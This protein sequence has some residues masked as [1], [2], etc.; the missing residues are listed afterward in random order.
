M[1]RC[2]YCRACVSVDV[3]HIKVLFRLRYYGRPFNTHNVS[4]HTQTPNTRTRIAQATTQ[5]TSYHGHRPEA[6]AKRSAEG[7]AR[8]SA[9]ARRDANTSV[10]LAHHA[11]ALQA[12]RTMRLSRPS[13]SYVRP[14]AAHPIASGFPLALMS[15]GRVSGPALVV[16]PTPPPLMRTR[17]AS[18]HTHTAT[19]AITTVRAAG[20]A[21]GCH[22]P[23]VYIQPGQTPGQP[24]R[25]PHAQTHTCSLQHRSRPATR[26]RTPTPRRTYT[27]HDTD[28][29]THNGLTWA[30]PAVTHTHTNAQ[31]SHAPV[32]AAAGRKCAG[33]CAPA[34]VDAKVEVVGRPERE[35]FGDA[36]KP[37]PSSVGEPGSRF[38]TPASRSKIEYP[39]VSRSQGCSCPDGCSSSAHPLAAVDHH[40][41]ARAS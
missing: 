18:A 14:H 6:T 38:C 40:S 39:S 27:A 33:E 35:R 37:P 41:P 4:P 1:S 15:N 9:P 25:P 8:G 5:G 23:S 17:T 2:P 22:R 36:F 13:R 32:V 11:T 26:G 10:P 3:Y 12:S 24:H 31:W 28:I 30:A 7:T 21:Q 29:R 16:T 20:R 19:L 34:A